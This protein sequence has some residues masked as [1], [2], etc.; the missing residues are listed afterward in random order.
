MRGGDAAGHR[1]RQPGPRAVGRLAGRA[2]RRRGQLERTTTTSATR[3]SRRPGSARRCE[4]GQILAADVVRLMAGRR[5]RHECRPLG[6]LDV[7]GPARSG[8]DRRGAVGTAR[9]GRRRTPS[10]C[11]A[12]WA[13]ARRRVSSAARP[14]WRRCRMRSSASPRA[15]AARWSSISGEA[16][17]GKTTLVAEAARAAFDGGACVLFGHCEE[18]L[19]TPVSALRRGARPLRHPR[20]RGRSSSRTSTR[21]VRSWPGWSRRWRAGCRGCRRRRRPTPT[22]SATC[23]SRRSSGCWSMVSQHQPVVLV[24]DDLQWADKASL[25]LLR[26]VIA[27]DQPMRL[28]VLGTYR[29]SELS[30]SHP[31]LETLAALHR[32]HGVARIEL[33][34]LDDTGVVSLMEAAAGH[35]PRRRRGRSRPRGVSRDRRQPVLRDRGAPPPRRDRGDLPGRHR[36][37][38]RR[39]HPRADGVA[40]QRPRGDRRPRRATGTRRRAGAVARRGDRPGLRPRRAGPRHQDLGRRPARHPRRRDGRGPGARARRHPRALQLRPRPH[41]THP[42]RGSRSHPPGPGAPA[43]RR[44]ARGPLRRPARVTGRRAGPP[45]VQRHPTHRPGQGHRLLAPGR[46]RRA[47]RPRPRR[48]PPLLRPGPRPLRPGRR[49]RSDPGHRPGRSGSAPPNARPATPPSATRSSTP[50]AGPPTSATPTGSSPPPWPTTG[51]SFSTVGTIDADKVEILELALD[52]LAADDPDRALVL[53][54]LCAELT[55][56]SPL[57]R[58]QALADEALAIAESVRR[59]RHHRAGP[60]PRLRARSSCRPCSS[61]RWPGRP[62]PCVGPSGSATRSCCSGP[63]GPAHG[64]PP[65]PATSTRWTAASRS[66]GRSPSSSTSRR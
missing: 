60:Q 63:L 41:P 54:T 9:R 36:P 40:R 18:D 55:Y 50:P 27:A 39:R 59:R 10:R 19:A 22:P 51:A 30:R 21:T 14:R 31:L 15:K 49:P 3:S 26:H 66:S 56:G 48:R 45:L 2:E 44:G 35:T 42:V 17:L 34:G 28:L 13:C 25:Q 33:T 38:G 64:P 52:R 47:R 16:G 5:S 65:A 20:P 43:G 29:D 12:V 4:S 46:R 57:E 37:V 24:L 58:R 62:T 1:T 53:A 32:Q 6:P 8:G 11:R 61:S 7:E 23:C